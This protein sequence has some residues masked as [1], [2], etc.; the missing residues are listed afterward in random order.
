MEE[1]ME[2]QSVSEQPSSASE[3]ETDDMSKGET[4]EVASDDH[5]DVNNTPLP[6]SQSTSAQALKGKRNAKPRTPKFIPKTDRHTRS[7]SS[8]RR[9]SYKNVL[10]NKKS[11]P[12]TLMMSS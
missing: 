5:H 12:Q 11:N 1:N 8:Q 9:K 3:A 6:A 7:S 2:K 10:M 4:D